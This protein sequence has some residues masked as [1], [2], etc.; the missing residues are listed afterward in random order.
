[1]TTI[2]T[3]TAAQMAQVDR[4]MMDE[5]GVDVLQLMEAAGLVVTEATRRQLGGDVAEARV[6]LLAGSGGNGGD[7]LVAARHLLARGAAPQV[8]LS[9]P[10]DTLPEVTAHQERAARA[11]GVPI[12]AMPEGEGALGERW[13]LIVDGLL[14]FSGH[15]DPRGAIAEMIRRANAHAAPVLAIDLPSGL[16]ATSGV[17][18][19]PCI[20][21]AT[22]VAL[23][24]PKHGFLTDA[25]RQVC[26]AIAV[27]DIGVPA[28]VLARLGVDVPATLFSRDALLPWTGPT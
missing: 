9:K 25:A 26:G 16:D 4:I 12:G 2:P 11:V 8:L 1:M 21:A 24:L 5:L 6:L 20:H 17:P 18:G 23:V 10:A 14:G 13:D 19:D 22:T 27:G 15:G 7:A 3:A 28:S